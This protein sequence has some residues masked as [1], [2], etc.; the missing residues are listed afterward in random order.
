MLEGDEYR[1]SADDASPKFRHYNTQIGIITAL[2]YVHQDQFESLEVAAELFRGFLES[3]P[4]GGV[5]FLADTHLIRETILP[6]RRGKVVLV[7]FGKECDERVIAEGWRDGRNRFSVR[8]IPFDLGLR[9]RHSCLNA[10]LAA[11]AAEAA[12]VSLEESAAALRTFDGVGGRLETVLDR[13]DLTVISD[14]AIYP[15]SIAEVVSSVRE[16]SRGRRFA[17]LFQPRYTLGDEEAY[18]RGLAEAFA[19]LDLLMLAEAVNFPGI[20]KAFP[21]EAQRLISLIPTSTSVIEVGPAMKSM[22]SWSGHVRDGDVWLV[23]VE[24]L[25]PEPLQSIR[26]FAEH[27]SR[28]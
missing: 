20:S 7:G 17:V 4:E 16:S 19:G 6:A 26:K 18:Y 27:K 21:F 15:R 23:M 10:A 3:I 24:P 13:D 14:L 2:D 9:G 12:G 28:M 25:F 5:A 22:D 8:D 11:L 1:T